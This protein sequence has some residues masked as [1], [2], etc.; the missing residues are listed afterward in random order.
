MYKFVNVLCLKYTQK[1]LVYSLLLTSCLLSSVIYAAPQHIYTL[2]ELTNMALKQNP[3]TRVAWAQ[4]QA[5]AAAVGI[6][7]S[8]YWPTIDVDFDMAYNSGQ[9]NNDTECASNNG[10]FC[11]NNVGYGPVL[12]LN[13]LLLDFGTRAAQVK[14]AQF[15]LQS[16]QFSQNATMQ[17]V[18]LQVNQAY[19]QL[20]GQQALVDADKI[21]RTQAKTNLDSA[22]ALH[23]QGMVTIGDVYQAESELQQAELTL[24]QAE[25]ALAIAQGQLA[26]AVG[27]PIQSPLSIVKL[28]EEINTKPMMQSMDKLL[29]IAKSHRPDLLAAQAQVKAAEANIVAARK[30]QWPTIQLSVQS[31]QT[32]PNNNFSNNGQQTDIQLSVNLPLFTGFQ[33]TY[34]IHQAEAQ[35][36]QAA[37]QRDVLNNQVDMEVWQAYYALQTAD[38]AIRSSSALLHSSIQAAKQAYGQYKAGVGN[39]LSVLTTQSTEASARAQYIQ[40]RLDW[41]TALAQ[42]AAALGTLDT[43][44]PHSGFT[45]QTSHRSTIE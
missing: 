37:T 14:N 27:L 44:P 10:L 41:Y 2:P 33:Q 4:V 31:G 20:L 1:I 19:Y 15:S 38:K 16:N 6:A 5:A 25:G 42:L 45:V 40:T 36:Q 39:I 28:P 29:D 22:N 21:T 13:Y 3:A 30:Q 23:K 43:A 32:F 18:I 34:A 17:Q 8:A 11:S 7:K 35:K 26:T 12:S 24:Q 9:T